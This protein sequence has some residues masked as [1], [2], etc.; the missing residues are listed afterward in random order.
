MRP[1]L[2]ALLLSATALCAPAALAQ[3]TLT[4]ADET[5]PQDA[6]PTQEQ[7]GEIVVTAQRRSESIQR[8]PVSLT[9]ITAETLTSRNLNDLTQVARAA[10][11]LQVGI[12]NT[13]SVR[14][15]GTLAFAGTIDSSVAL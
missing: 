14:G 15:V 7:T 10:P 11:S 9:A 2:T 6:S 1:A 5:A 13:F 3:T 4:A 8:V 12:D